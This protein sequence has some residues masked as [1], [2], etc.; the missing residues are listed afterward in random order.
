MNLLKL[1][2]V[3]HVD[4]GKSTLIGKLLQQ[5]NS[6]P[7]DRMEEIKHAAKN[8]G[9]EMEFAYLLDYLEEEREQGI[10]IDTTQVFFK[11]GKRD[12]VIIDSPGQVEFVKNMVTGASQAEA[13]VLIVDVKEGMK[14]QGRRHAYLL[15]L[16]GIEQVIVAL[17]KMDLAG[18]EKNTYEKIKGEA[19]RFLASTGMEALYYI[20][21][22]AKKGENITRKSK[23]MHWY[24]GPTFVEG[25]DKLKEKESLADK[26]L[27]F[28]VQDIYKIADKRIAAGKLLSGIIKRGEEIK[29]LPLH[30]TTKVE[31]VERYLEN[32]D[33]AYPGESIGIIT[34]EPVP[35]SRGDIICLPGKEPVLTD[36][37]EASIFWISSKELCRGKSLSIRCASQET[38]C[39]IETIK[40]RVDSSTLEIIQENA[41]ILKNPEVGEVVIKT[42]NPV[43]LQPFRELQELGRFVLEEGGNICAGGI[44]TN[45]DTDNPV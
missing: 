2:I 35:I 12:Y 44:V 29:I 15:S 37:F 41:D 17:N 27:I 3:G 18:Y 13:A 45:C 24:N 33:A 6:L 10:S 7:T 31:S 21:V 42:K 32:R 1:V 26:P 22:S 34:R 4:H 23:K 40:K 25:L 19:A 43:A 20:P 36:R 8:A 30:R 39:S 9:K 38:T 5:T 14:E 11:T 28:P 16:L